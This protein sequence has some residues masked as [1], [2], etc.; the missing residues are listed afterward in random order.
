MSGTIV[1]FHS[2]FFS[3]TFFE[4]LASESPRTGSVDERLDD[5][6]EQTGVEIPE[7]DIASHV[8][9][10]RAE[11]D[12]AGVKHMVSFASVPPEIPVL[13]RAAELA[14]G[15]LTPFALINPTAVGAADRVRE[16]LTAGP[17]SGILLSPAA[18][19]YRMSDPVVRPVL[20]TLQASGGC[21]VVHC[22]LLVVKLK[23]L[24]GLPR[25]QD[26]AFANPLDVI[27]AANA[28]PGARFVIPHFGAGFLRETLMAGVMC[29]NVLVD[30]SSSNSWLATQPERLTLAH[31]FA[32]ALGVFGADR[33]LFGT[34]SCTFP[35][36]F[37]DDLLT[38]QRQAMVE[39]GVSE[40]E[41]AQILG[42]NAQRL[43]GLA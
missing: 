42:G 18:H 39:A 6:A 5:L 19:H 10:W 36:G 30:T 21:A 26:L 12:G 23:D 27:P 2:H 28:F 11:L 7:A 16:L 37:R 24:L 25:N 9:R 22:G 8:A 34:D 40:Q 32:K 43:L 13:A 17:F 15:W 3:R 31:V 35:R 33:I 38:E 14:G 29:P 41:T 1:D 20:E 4:T